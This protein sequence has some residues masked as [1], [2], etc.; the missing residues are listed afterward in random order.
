MDV[1]V[2]KQD[3]I[4]CLLYSC[5]YD[6]HNYSPTLKD[7][8]PFKLFIGFNVKVTESFAVFFG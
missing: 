6:E 3:L 5:D 7:Y 4:T 2:S 1:E 8:C